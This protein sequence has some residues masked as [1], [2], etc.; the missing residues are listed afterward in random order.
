MCDQFK[1]HDHIWANS[2]SPYMGI[3][4]LFSFS[5]RRSFSY[6]FTAMACNS[7]CPPRKSEPAPMNSRAGK[8]FVVK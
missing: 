2:S 3:F 6:L 8:S 7:K 4:A 1:A 5:D